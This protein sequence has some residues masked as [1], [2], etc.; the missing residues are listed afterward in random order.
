MNHHRQYNEQ[1][2]RRK[3][4]SR[5]PNISLNPGLG[6]GLFRPGDLF[7]ADGV[8]PRELRKEGPSSA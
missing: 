5:H 1:P 4:G 8:V 7:S 3:T 6:L 2:G